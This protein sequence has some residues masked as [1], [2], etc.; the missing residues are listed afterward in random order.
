MTTHIFFGIL[1][2]AEDSPSYPIGRTLRGGESMSEGAS[3]TQSTEY[4]T[5]QAGFE[6]R[7][8]RYNAESAVSCH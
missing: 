5:A 6:Q 7:T 8:N 1:S 4:V 2:G 3:S